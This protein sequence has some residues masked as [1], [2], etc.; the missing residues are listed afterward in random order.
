MRAAAAR[1]HEQRG[2]RDGGRVGLPGEVRGG[3]CALLA[4]AREETR[5]RVNVRRGGAARVLGGALLRLELLP[6]ARVAL[7]AL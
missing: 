1:R 3:E 4:F 5:D 7:A 2:R 6:L